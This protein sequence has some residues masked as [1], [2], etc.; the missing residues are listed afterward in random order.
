LRDRYW[1]GVDG[2]PGAG[3]DTLV[4]LVDVQVSVSASAGESVTLVCAPL[5]EGII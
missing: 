2:F 1:G 5:V 4:R 3:L